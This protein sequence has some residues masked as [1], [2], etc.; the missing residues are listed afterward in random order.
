MRPLR[1]RQNLCIKRLVPV[2]DYDWLTHIPSN[3]KILHKHTALI[4]LQQYNCVSRTSCFKL[5]DFVVNFNLLERPSLDEW[6]REMDS[7]EEEEADQ[8]TDDESVKQM[9]EMNFRAVYISKITYCS[10]LFSIQF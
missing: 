4:A 9:K 5:S 7:M 3:C 6:W 1:Y 10:S 8:T 2:F